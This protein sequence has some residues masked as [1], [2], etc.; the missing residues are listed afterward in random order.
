[1]TL[2]NLQIPAAKREILLSSHTEQLID[3]LEEAECLFLRFRG[4][5][6]HTL[7]GVSRMRAC[8]AGGWLLEGKENFWIPR[9]PVARRLDDQGHILEE[10][11]AP[12]SGLELNGSGLTLF[13]APPAGF[14]TDLA[15][16]RLTPQ[17]QQ[18]LTDLS[19]IETQAY[20]LWGS[21][22]RYSHP[23]DLYLHLIHGW[24]YENRVSWPKYWKICSEND[25]H[26]L[27]VLF[28]GLARATGKTLY[29]L[30]KR[31]LLLAVLDRQADDGG[32]YHGEWTDGMESHFR[33][34][35]SALHLL[36][37]AYEEGPDATIAEGLQ[38]GTEFLLQ[39]ADRLDC[40]LWF[41]HDSLELTEAS[42]RQSP[43]QWLPCRAFGKSVSDM[44]V[45]N[46]HW[47][48]TIAVGR[49]AG[50]LEESAWREAAGEANR[51]TET[52][53]AAIPAAWLYRL[54]FGLIALSFL[55]TERAAA[56][57]LWR[58][59]LKRL[60]W[61][62]LIPCFH[63][64]KCRFP[65]LVMPGGYL[66]RALCLKGISTAYQA[67][68]VMDLV[69]LQA[70]F[71][72]LKLRSYIDD[73]VAFTYR[74]GLWQRWAEDERTRYAYGF[75]AE[76]LH[77]LCLLDP[78]PALRSRLAG[79]MARLE[80]LGLG[81]PPG[82]LGGDQERGF[83]G[84]RKLDLHKLP[85]G[86]RIADLSTPAGAEYLLLGTGEGPVRLNT[87]T[88]GTELNWTDPEGRPLDPEFSLQ[89]GQWVVGR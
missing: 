56:L 84:P 5:A 18:E 53:L 34:H 82:L 80:E 58:R 2:K 29:R 76:A 79:T 89:P 86:V 1:M 36:L 41:L 57:P 78:D 30:F 59:A 21:H 66:D 22:T 23:A 4:P 28:S 62:Y 64:L 44:L 6:D 70:R 13:L 74:S 7:P 60:G 55:P 16:W 42:M 32:W 8:P 31:Q 61:K 38:R 37:D 9:L 25:A 24:V 39:R 71:P 85:P 3:H 50:L 75:W 72:Q 87:G 19:P 12:V 10:T 54:V 77:R 27:Y 63:H 65:R 20:F 69:R 45:L 51:A 83:A 33:L 47:D 81:Q 48:T 26:A 14:V 46:S 67:I 15:V 40:G 88:L 52:V 35:T 43:F 73:A 68:N 49:G 17:L 11:P